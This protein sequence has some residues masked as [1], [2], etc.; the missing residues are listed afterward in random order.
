MADLTRAQIEN[1]S[2]EERQKR[3]PEINEIA[4]KYDPRTEPTSTRADGQQ[5]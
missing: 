5:Q 4:S 3:L 1:M 2:T